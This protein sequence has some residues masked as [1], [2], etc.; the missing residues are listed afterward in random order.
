MVTVRPVPVGDRW[1]VAVQVE[2]PKTHLV[3]VSTGTGYIMCGALDVAL[4]N[5][6]L[7]ERG[8]VAARA[9]GVKTVEELLEAPIT[10]LTDAAR[11]LGVREGMPGK[12]ALAR[13]FV[14]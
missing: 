4:L 13:M 12:E 3:A 11:A 8:I 2:L 6:R 5:T 10:D 14:D 7:K 1:A 9:L